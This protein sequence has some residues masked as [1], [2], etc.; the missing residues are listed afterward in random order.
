[1]V[2]NP[3]NIDMS[4]WYIEVDGNKYDFHVWKE[5]LDAWG[6]IKKEQPRTAFLAK[7]N[8]N[9]ETITLDCA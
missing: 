9:G 1:M 8:A 2:S 5:A 3:G 6:I 4:K 7:R